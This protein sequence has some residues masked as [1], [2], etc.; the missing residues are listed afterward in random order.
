MDIIQFGVL[1][2]ILKQSGN[3]NAKKKNSENP[4]FY[5]GGGPIFVSARERVVYE[6]DGASESNR[7]KRT[8]INTST[9]GGVILLQEELI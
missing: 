3:L 4:I 8:V 1:L 5:L 9:N 6:E 7:D 2:K